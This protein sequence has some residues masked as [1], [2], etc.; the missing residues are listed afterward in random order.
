MSFHQDSDCQH[1]GRDLPGSRFVQSLRP[2][3]TGLNRRFRYG[4][5]LNLTHSAEGKIR[6]P[7]RR[8]DWFSSYLEGRTQCVSASTGRSELV[9]LTCG[10]PHGS[11]L[12]LVKFIAY[13]EDLHTAINKELIW[14]GSQAN[15]DR[16]Q[17][18][19]TTIR[20]G[21]SDI[22]P[23]DCVHYLGVMLDSSLSIREH[24]TKVTS[25]C[26]S[27]PTVPR[28]QSHTGHR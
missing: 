16:L 15:L 18:M 5:P 2:C 27:S 28:V 1:S 10:V 23:I 22:K 14:F 24:I 12:G 7:E 20:L 6:R 21:L 9:E 25:T 26:F 11:V 4:R 19:D 17:A 8:D 13:T 3:T